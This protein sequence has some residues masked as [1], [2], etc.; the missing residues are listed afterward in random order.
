MATASREDKLIL[1]DGKGLKA[2]RPGEQRPNLEY[3]DG[4]D[5]SHRLGKLVFKQRIIDR[6]NDR[7]FEHIEDYESHEVIHYCDELLSKHTG[8][9]SAKK[10]R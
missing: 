6:D 1:R 4:P 9:G 7:Y 3:S 8:H 2:R 5:M 10:K